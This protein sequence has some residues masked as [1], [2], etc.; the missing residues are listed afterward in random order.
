MIDYGVSTRI[1]PLTVSTWQG[2]APWR[3]LG[4]LT[5]PETVEVVISFSD[6]SFAFTSPLTASMSIFS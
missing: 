2:L 4:T 3:L 5:S 1:S 6:S